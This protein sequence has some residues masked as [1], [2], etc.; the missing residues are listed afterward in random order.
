VGL[1][2]R[3]YVRDGSYTSRLAGW[4]MEPFTP[5]V[6]YL[7]I[8][9][10]IVF[11]LQIFVTRTPPEAKEGKA[12][13]QESMK[14]WQEEMQ[15]KAIELD[16]LSR[17]VAKARLALKRHKGDQAERDQLKADLAQRE[18]EFKEKQEEV[19]KINEEWTKRYRE[20]FGSGFGFGSRASLVQEWLQ[21]SPDKVKRGEVWRLL[22]AAF[23]HDR[24]LIWHIFF[25]MLLLY[26]FGTRLESMYGSREFLLFYLVAAVCGSAA[27]VGLAWYTGSNTPAIGASGAVMGVMML[28]TIYYPFE[29]FMVF[30]VVPIPLW[31]MLGLYV[32]YDLHPVL[33]AL[34]GDQFFTGVA[35]AGHLGGLL[36]GFLY[37]RFGL[38]LEAVFGQRWKGTRIPRR[39]SS[40][41]EPLRDPIILSYP[42]PDELSERVDQVLQKISEHGKESLTDEERDVL[43][44]ASARYR[45]KK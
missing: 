13:S 2:S 37:Y 40:K 44:Q 31:A 20:E 14:R 41:P 17:D 22:T 30:W 42:K 39:R 23:C 36:F 11:L 28:Y 1:E 12:P 9:N 6:K 19:R 21:L 38:R 25:N 26:W 7:I 35:H 10:V 32:L 15:E 3:D 29:R 43:I 24:I 5:V 18:A 27:Y 4:G 8:L 33:L 16:E 34:A 45:G